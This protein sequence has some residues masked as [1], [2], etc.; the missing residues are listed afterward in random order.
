MCVCVLLLLG[1]QRKVRFVR[2]ERE[3]YQRNSICRRRR[4]RFSLPIS[5]LEIS[6]FTHIALHP[7]SATLVQ[8]V[9][10][11]V[12]FIEVNSNELLHGAAVEADFHFK[13]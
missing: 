13:I 2:E 1:F 7:L 11:K 12:F 10:M 3:Y 6:I 4:H 9:T 8:R 5:A